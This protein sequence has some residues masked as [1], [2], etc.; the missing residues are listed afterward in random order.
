MQ[1]QPVSIKKKPLYP[2]TVLVSAFLLGG[3]LLLAPQVGHAADPQDDAAFTCASAINVMDCIRQTSSQAPLQPASITSLPVNSQVLGFSGPVTVGLRYDNYLAWIMDVGYAQSFYDAAAAIKLSAGLNERRANVSLGYAIT[4]RQQIK[5]TYEY[6]AQNL[7]FDYAS[8]KVNEWVNQ[9]AFGGAYRYIIGQNI[10]QSVELYGAYTKA[11]SKELSEVEMYTDNILTQINQRRIAGGTEKTVGTAVTL[12]PFKSTIVKL[13]GGYSTLGFDTQWEKDQPN[14]VVAYNA[15]ITQLLTPTT[16]IS[17]GIGNTASGQAYTARASQILPWSLEAALI[18]QYSAETSGIPGSSSVTASLSYPAPKTYQNTLNASLSNIK[19]WV[20]KPVVY[21]SRVLAKAEERLLQVQITTNPIPASSIP[22]YT[23]ITPIPTNTYFNFDTQV[24]DKISYNIASTTDSKGNPIPTGF[25]NLNLQIT[26]TDSYNA[27]LA[28]SAPTTEAMMTPGQYIVSVQAQ[29][30]RN[31]QIVSEVTN[32]IHISVVTNPN[33]PSASWIASA[34]IPAATPGTTSYKFDLSTLIKNTSTTPQTFMFKL[35]EPTDW[36][37]IETD[38]KTLVNSQTVPGNIT[39]QPLSL[40]ATS[41]STGQALDPNPQNAY[42]VPVGTVTGANWLSSVSSL[43]DATGVDYS[44]A[45]VWLNPYPP[46]PTTNYPQYLTQTTVGTPPQPTQDTLGFS[47][48]SGH[49][50]ACGKLVISPDTGQLSGTPQGVSGTC[51]VYVRVKSALMGSTYALAPQS[52][53]LPPVTPPNWSPTDV[54]LPN[55]T[56]NTNYSNANVLL[57]PYVAHTDKQP[58]YLSKTTVGTT[59]PSSDTLTFALLTTEANACG[60]WLVINRDTGQLTSN[61]YPPTVPTPTLC[62]VYI[63]MTSLLAGAEPYMLATKSINL[64]VVVVPPPV[65]QTGTNLKCA[66]PFDDNT[67]NTNCRLNTFLEPGYGTSGLKMTFAGGKTVENSWEIKNV[68]NSTEFYLVRHTV[69]TSFAWSGS[70][71]DA[72]DACGVASGVPVASC[73]PPG[74]NVNTVVV[75]VSNDSGKPAT[76]GTFTITLNAETNPLI[77]KAIST[78]VL[79]VAAFNVTGYYWGFGL[80]GSS[81]NGYNG[82]NSGLIVATRKSDGALISHAP[83]TSTHA[84]GRVF[85]MAKTTSLGPDI[86]VINPSFIYMGMGYNGSTKLVSGDQGTYSPT[87]YNGNHAAAQTPTFL[88][89][90]SPIGPAGTQ[91]V[92]FT[93]VVSP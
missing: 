5:L 22:V 40:I 47:L 62:N 15:E 80:N 32:P 46:H 88:S 34:T 26:P 73:S 14:A 58:Q 79:S 70:L 37:K 44:N 89:V 59:T 24:Y 1:I 90:G 57:N 86:Y 74:V 38:G 35:A 9:N 93:V 31:A 12:T 67:S 29:G 75:Y 91:T 36:L 69:P 6:L 92:T 81:P 85:S 30:Y 16:L 48:D 21:Q 42:S 72:F 49:A 19:D 60:S 18:G 3:G 2:L 41:Q 64:P 77:F 10:L 52:I 84:T 63:K 51:N 25:N 23:E 50:D 28:S 27:T 43:P 66:M 11:A 87:G 53:Q 7:P 33:L 17:T 65:W 45:N 56:V 13:G 68:S 78:P 71:L 8:G 39:T 61:G 55:A 20:M 76:T 83:I 82:D 4:P 54:T